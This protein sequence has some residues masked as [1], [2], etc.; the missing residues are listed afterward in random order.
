M[1]SSHIMCLD[2]YC[3]WKGTE[4]QILIP[5]DCYCVFQETQCD[6]FDLISRT[7]SASAKSWRDHSEDD[8]DY[9][10]HD[11]LQS[12]IVSFVYNVGRGQVSLLK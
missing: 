4:A 1:A 7:N 6:T 2:L 8:D 10:L 9:A 5:L 11:G 12:G 3:G